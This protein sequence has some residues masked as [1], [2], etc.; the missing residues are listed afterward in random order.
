MTQDNRIT[1]GGQIDR[2]K[3]LRFTFDGHHLPPLTRRRTSAT[4]V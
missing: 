4:V 3:T 1:S 2:T